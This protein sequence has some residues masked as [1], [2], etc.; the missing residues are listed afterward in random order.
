MVTRSKILILPPAK[1][2]AVWYLPTC[3]EGRCGPASCFGQ[4]YV[5][6]SDGYC[7]NEV[8]EPL[9]DLSRSPF[10]P[11]WWWKYTSKQECLLARS[12][13]DEHP[14]PSHTSQAMPITAGTR[15]N[16]RNY[17]DVNINSLLGE[18]LMFRA[19]QTYHFESSM[20]VMQERTVTTICC[21]ALDGTLSTYLTFC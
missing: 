12:F 2:I 7:Q 10:L 1:H 19:T 13:H 3:S 8:Q 18:T 20:L 5:F 15:N 14:F 21:E 9:Q 11:Q 6:G 16:A 17:S 4:R